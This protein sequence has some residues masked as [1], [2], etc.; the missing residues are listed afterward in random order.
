MGAVASLLKPQV[1]PED[2][3]AD[4][5]GLSAKEGHEEQ[6]DEKAKNGANDKKA[7]D[8][9][10]VEK[11]SGW[12][13]MGSKVEYIDPPMPDVG[14]RVDYEKLL[15]RK[16]NVKK[17]NKMLFAVVNG[18]SKEASDRA[19]EIPVVENLERVKVTEPVMEL[20]NVRKTTI[21]DRKFTQENL[22]L[23]Q[24]YLSLRKSALNMMNHNY[25]DKIVRKLDT[26]LVAE[27]RT[28]LNLHMGSHLPDEDPLGE[29]SEEEEYERKAKEKEEKK[30]KKAATT[31]PKGKPA[32]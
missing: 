7:K 24:K 32:V 27:T 9:A 19:A 3:D 14:M 1:L 21:E 16:L 29:E 25:N 28:K 17:A 31:P 8:G 11:S 12:G 22:L 13:F 6:K 20:I 23:S 26:V 10:P 5:E 18:D 2:I 30:K 4:E 15:A